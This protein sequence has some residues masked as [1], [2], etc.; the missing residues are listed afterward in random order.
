MNTKKQILNWFYVLLIL[1][2]LIFIIDYIRIA[3]IN[4]NISKELV[5]SPSNSFD[6]SKTEFQEALKLA[7]K[8]DVY[9]MEKLVMYDGVYMSIEENQ[10]WQNKILE[11]AK[12]GN[13]EAR[14]FFP[15]WHQ[16]KPASN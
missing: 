14:R 15:D 4:Y 12:A 6:L 10:Y 9:A 13:L 16:N 11:A 7:Q 8:G 1:I 3:I 5:Y 2:A